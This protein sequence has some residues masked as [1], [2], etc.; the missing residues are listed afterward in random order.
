MNKLT[1]LVCAPLCAATVATVARGQDA[2]P[3]QNPSASEI[4][5]KLTPPPDTD[6]TRTRSLRGVVI[7]KADRPADTT[8]AAKD[9]KDV[10]PGVTADIAVK[11]PSIDLAINFEFASAKLTP[12]ARI[13]LDALGQALNDAALR[14]SRFRVAGHTDAV[15]GDAANMT[16]SRQRAQS[17][18][19][20]LAQQHKVET[21]R[22]MVEGYGRSRL[23]DRNNPNSAVNRRVQIENLGAQ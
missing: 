23:L 21:V 7:E 9:A 11:P 4:I 22:L 14:G 19:E 8:G 1:L 2:R 6:G 13:A 12:D 20:Y 18:A 17:V 3:M 10:K 16:L 5:Q 15:G